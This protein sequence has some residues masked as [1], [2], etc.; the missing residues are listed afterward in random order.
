MESNDLLI[1]GVD[2]SFAPPTKNTNT[3]DA[4]TDDNNDDDAIA[5]YVV[6]QNDKVILQNKLRFRLDAPYIPSYLAMRELH[7]LQKLIRTT[8]EENRL[9]KD[10]SPIPIANVILVDG[11]GILHERSAGIATCLGV[12]LNRKTI[13]VGKTLYC[14]DGFTRENVGEGFE[15]RMRQFVSWCRGEFGAGGNEQQGRDWVVVCQ[16]PIPATNGDSDSDDK[17]NTSSTTKPDDILPFTEIINQLANY[18]RGFAIPL[19]GRSGRIHGAALL[20]HGG[21]HTKGGVGTK[22][23]IYISVGN[24]VSLQ[25]AVVICAGVSKVRIPEPVRQADL[26]GRDWMREYY[27]GG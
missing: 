19:R 26:V 7:P 13:G 23:P 14:F 8:E 15:L 24:D 9:K 18:C 12:S 16:T 21:T 6:Y 10:N 22:N 4:N 3:N 1:G 17:S 2:V 5:V 20:G 25:E 27:S 11:N